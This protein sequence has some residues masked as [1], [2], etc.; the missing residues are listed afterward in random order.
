MPEQN[1]TED[2]KL[3]WNSPIPLTDKGINELNDRMQSIS[4]TSP[5]QSKGTTTS[6]YSDINATDSLKDMKPDEANR[7]QLQKM[8]WHKYR[9]F[10]GLLSSIEDKADLVTG[11]GFS[12]YSIN[13][14]I[15]AVVDDTMYSQR[16]LLFESIGEWPRRMLAEGELFLLNIVDTNGDTTTRVVE[17]DKIEGAEDESGLVT[18]PDDVTKTLF[19][20]Y[21]KGNG[22]YV[23][24]PSEEIIY[25]PELEKKLI[26]NS[27]Y[28]AEKTKWAKNDDPAF[29]KFGGYYKYII[30]W[31]NLSGITKIRR[32]TPT[33]RAV[34]QWANL[35]EDSIK[36]GLD[37][38]KAQSSYAVVLEFADTPA[39]KFAYNVW[40]AMSDDEK[41]A[42]GL[43]GT[44]KPGDRIFLRPGVVMKMLSPA[45]SKGS[46]ENLDLLN[47]VGAGARTPQDL[48]QGQSSGSTY[49]SLKMSRNPFSINIENLQEKFRNFLVY[50]Y[51]RAVFYCKSAIIQSFPTL[52]KKK[53]T[54]EVNKGKASFTYQMVEP[55]R[56]IGISMPKI[57][58]TEDE[59]VVRTMLGSKHMGLN[60]I[61]ISKKAMAEELGFD[62]YDRQKRERMLE[63]EEYGEDMLLQDAEA[64]QE[65]QINKTGAEPV[66]KPKSNGAALEKGASANN[67]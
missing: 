25:N 52:F 47:M 66:K 24:I 17:P 56:L 37:Y 29:K 16:N 67:A 27:N 8:C 65:G 12:V 5:W 35:Y 13:A 7:S 3:S 15:Q 53:V 61:G 49:A 10:P 44:L 9:Y 31:K 28:D 41:K 20:R 36:W 48:M 58:L 55:A 26:G 60:S 34:I 63:E 42:T 46:G 4:Q 32:D 18:D 30:H 50:R 1:T 2:I 45:L 40:A 43:S 51:F 22:D 11:K 21:N 19:Y 62:D 33:L 54:T 38:K 14:K 59:G 64:Q 23:L 57:K 6:V 39:G